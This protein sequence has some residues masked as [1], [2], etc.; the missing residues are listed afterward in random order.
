[1]GQGILNLFIDR[2]TRYDSIAIDSSL[3]I[4][5]IEEHKQYLPFTK[6][7][8]RKL[9]PEGRLEGI[10]TTLV[11][12]EILTKPIAEKRYDLVLAYKSFIAGFPHLDLKS[13]DDKIA[14]KAAYFRAQYNLRTP[15]AIHIATAYEGKAEA[16]LG[17]DSNWK[18]VKEIPVILLKEFRQV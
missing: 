2:L 6:I 5:H 9:L 15:D 13:L 1:M 4:Y 18:K 12:T 3:F 7:L 17:N 16:I 10:C 14:E 11:L 8:F